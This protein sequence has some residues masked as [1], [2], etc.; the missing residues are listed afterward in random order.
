M[1]IVSGLEVLRTYRFSDPNPVP[2]LILSANVTEEAIR[3]CREAGAAE[4][5]AKPVRASVL[6]DAIDRHLVGG[7]Q[8]V[9]I[10]PPPRSDGTPVTAVHDTPVLDSETIA[11]LGKLSRDPAFLERLM[12]G[13]RSDCARLQGDISEALTK[14]HYEALKDAAHALKGA[15]GSVGAVLLHQFALTLEATA[16]DTLGAKAPALAE[17][18]RHVVAR[19]LRALDAHMLERQQKQSSS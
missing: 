2:V 6:L 9:A 17:E 15:A 4:F 7:S 18:L 19:T 3:H 5:V 13:F 10:S 1:P 16:R 11:E 12:E 14:R 8:R